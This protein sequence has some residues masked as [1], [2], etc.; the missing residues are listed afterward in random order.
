MGQRLTIGVLLL[1]IVMLGG[2]WIMASALV[3]PRQFLVGDVPAGLEG[4]SIRLDSD[5][6]TTLAGWDIPGEQSKGVIILLHGI[7]ASRIAMRSRARWLNDLGY[8]TVLIDFSSHAE[9]TGERITI[10]YQERHDVQAVVDYVS[11]QYPDRPI[12]VIAVSMGGAATLLAKPAAVDALVIESTY[13]DLER[14]VYNRVAQRLGALAWLPTQL[15]LWQLQPRMGFH[16]DDLRPVDAISEW[17][18]PVLVIAGDSD[19]YTPADETRE[20]YAAAP[21]PKSLWLV[22]GAIHENLYKVAPDAYR[23][24]VAAFF[25]RWLQ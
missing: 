8:T 22:P 20:L 10:G 14:A 25:S 3:A 7:R 12:G 15:L 4:R 19:P 23:E 24:R 9:S 18:S 17:H 6:G 13:P 2:S 1:L 21:S 16:A 11:H 5:S